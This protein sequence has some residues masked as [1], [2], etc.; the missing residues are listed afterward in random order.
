MIYR[1]GGPCAM[2]FTM[3]STPCE[4]HFF[5]TASIHQVAP[6]SA[7]GRTTLPAALRETSEDS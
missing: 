6:A 1:F 7:K 5:H 3:P 2:R 4:C